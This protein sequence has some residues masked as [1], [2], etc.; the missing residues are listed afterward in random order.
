MT[1]GPGTRSPDRPGVAEGLR[2]GMLLSSG[3]A[4]VIHVTVG[5]PVLVV[6]LAALVGGAGLLG[7]MGGSG[8][9]LGDRRVLRAG[10]FPALA[11]VVAYDVS[12]LL[13]VELGGFPIHPF[14]AF[15]HFG[16]ALVGSGGSE[17]VRWVVG[18]GFHVIN[19]IA[20]ALAYVVLL[21]RR[22]VLT[23]IGW[24]LGLE[25][26]MIALYPRWLQIAELQLFL[27]MS[28]L[29]HVAYGATLGWTAARAVVRIPSRP[30]TP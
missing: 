12:R 17:T 18:S 26:A 9:V 16:G 5:L 24:G 11:A 4:L 10:L 15:P 19:G 27:T 22:G 30:A 6:W 2:S 7:A 8:G 3:L 28:V 23:G 14:G 20:F 25:L 13:L 29:G 21:G 1:R